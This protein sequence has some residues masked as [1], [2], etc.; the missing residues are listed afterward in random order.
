MSCLT[1]RLFTRSGVEAIRETSRANVSVEVINVGELNADFY[2]GGR[3]F[4]AETGGYT[5]VGA[6]RAERAVRQIWQAAGRYFCVG[7]R[8][9]G[10]E[11][12]RVRRQVLATRSDRCYGAIAA[13]AATS[14]G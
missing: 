10:R 3:G 2:D 5:F 8:H 9:L 11:P 6:N 13:S 12:L 1:K 7:D 14:G 4:A